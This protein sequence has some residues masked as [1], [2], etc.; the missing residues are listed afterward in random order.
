MSKFY[1]VAHGFERGIYE[2]WDDAKKQIDDFPQ[3]VYK[4]FSTR[5]EAE[6][7]FNARQPKKVELAFPEPNL[8]KYYAVARGYSVGVFTN[9]EDV[10]KYIEDYPQPLYK[11]FDNLDDAVA[12][13]NKFFHGNEKKDPEQ[14]KQ[15]KAPQNEES[16]NKKIPKED[17]TV[18]YYAV[19]RGHTTG[20]FLSW[21]ECKKQTAGFKGAKFKKFDNEEEAKMFAEGK[22]LKQIEEAVA[23]RKR[24]AETSSSSDN[25]APEKKLKNSFVKLDKVEIPIKLYEKLLNSMAK[26][27]FYAVA[28][29]RKVGIYTTWDQCRVQVDGYPQARFKKFGT[30]NEARE[31]IASFQLARTAAVSSKSSRGNSL[32]Q[33]NIISRKRKS[34]ESTDLAVP[35]RLKDCDEAI[36][37]DAPVVYTD[38]ACSGNGQNSAKAGYGVYW[39]ADHV[40]NKWGPVHGVATN[41]RGEL[42]AVDVAL[43]QAISKKMECL[44][45]RTDSQLLMKSMDCYIENWKRNSWKTSTGEAVKNQ[46]LLRSIDESIR[47]IHVKFE[48][49]PGHS[50]VDGNEAADELARRGAEMYRD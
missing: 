33:S 32:V 3:A 28:K 36:W 7:Y 2:N 42:L 39:G 34:T 15:E 14:E 46:D 43:K 41:N 20:V 8:E 5:E 30:E 19:A 25:A 27:G 35:K 13:F 45:V 37:E 6:E 40:D 12:Y 18:T 23:G 26:S 17:K 11:K 21:E 10:K 29:G 47:K 38:G 16:S 1:A 24:P 22:T 44:I 50:G 31:F 48:Y 9:Y 49:V 4:K